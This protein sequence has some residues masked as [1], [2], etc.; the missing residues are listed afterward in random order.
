[1]RPDLVV[2]RGIGIAAA[3]S[4]RLPVTAVAGSIRVYE[5]PVSGEKGRQKGRRN[6]ESSPDSRIRRLISATVSGGAPDVVVV[7][8]D[9]DADGSGGIAKVRL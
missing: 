7:G 8:V 3:P 2:S 1:V 5:R 4:I 6:L 9:V